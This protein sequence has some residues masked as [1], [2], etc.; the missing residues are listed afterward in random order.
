MGRV[1]HSGGCC[2]SR[3]EGRCG[4]WML[5][6]LSL[7]HPLCISSRPPCHAPT[8]RERRPCLQR[9][10]GALIAG[11]G[12]QVETSGVGGDSIGVEIIAELVRAP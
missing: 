6:S 8:R 5:S 7:Y 11:Q 12:D 1:W 3:A 4:G 9:R 10:G 2:C